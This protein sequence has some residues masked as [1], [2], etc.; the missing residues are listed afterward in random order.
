MSTEKVEK[1]DG[2][3]KVIQIQIDRDHFTVHVE[4]MSGAE[5]RH[6]PNPPIAANRDLFEVVIHG[7]DRK[8]SD[9]DQ[10]PLHNGQRFFSAPGQ[11]NPGNARSGDKG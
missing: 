1:G 2:P 11:I 3:K 7:T 4:T 10:V 6:L 9:N 8:I 5:L